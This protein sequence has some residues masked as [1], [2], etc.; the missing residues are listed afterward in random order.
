MKCLR[1]I[2]MSAVLL[3]SLLMAGSAF[4]DKIVCVADGNGND[5]C[6]IT[7][8]NV[9][10][11]STAYSNVSLAPGDTVTVTAQGCVQTGGSGATWKRYVDPS[12]PNSDH[13]Y[14]GLISIP[15]VT[16][17]LV[18]LSTV[19]GIVLPPSTGG[20]LTL[21]Y[22]D[23]DYSDNGYWSH[24]DGTDGQCSDVSDPQSGRASLLLVIHHASGPFLP[25]NTIYGMCQVQDGLHDICHIDR[26]DVTHATEEYLAISLRPGDTVGI[27]AQGC[28]QTGGGGST[29][30]RYVNPSGANSDHLYHGLIS[31]PGVTSGMVRLSTVVGNPSLPPSTGGTL[32]L[33]YEDDDYSDNGYWSHDDG[34]EDQCKGIGAASLDLTITHSG[35]GLDGIEITQVIQNMSGSV[36]LIAAKTTWARA[37]LSSTITPSKTVTATL[38]IRNAATVASVDITASAPSVLTPGISLRARRESWTGSLNFLLPASIVAA[39]TATYEVL[40]ITDSA[41]GQPLACMNCNF[42]KVV[43]FTTSPA[44]R[45]RAIGLQYTT[46]TPP[47]A[48]APV[49]AD[50]TLLSSWLLRAYPVP[51]IIFTNTTI[52]STNTWPFACTDANAQLAAIRGNDVS[53]GTD[54]R[55]HYLG[56][57][58]NGGGYMRGCASG[59]PTTADPTTV[60]SAPTGNPVGPNAPI[61]AIGDTDASFGDWY[62]GHELSHTFGRAHPGF[63]NGNSKDDLS[64]PNPNGQISDDLGTDTGLDVGDA[65]AAIALSVL[66]GASHFDIMTYCNQ[67][68]WFSAYNFASVRTRLHDEDTSGASDGPVA[69]APKGATHR[70][71]PAAPALKLE[72]GRFIHVV[73]TVDITAQTGKIRYV[74]PVKK[75]APQEPSRLQAE[76]RALTAQGQLIATYKVT[77][78]K[79]TDVPPREH[80]T[81]LIDAA[82]PYSEKIGRIQLVLTDKVNDEFR[83]GQQLPPSPGPAKLERIA[84]G[85]TSP[86]PGFDYLLRWKPVT[87]PGDHITYTV[88][89]SDDDSNWLTIGIG[90][91]KPLLGITRENANSRFLRVT[92]TNGFRNSEPVT[93]SRHYGTLKI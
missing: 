78:R 37:Y 34:T 36:P 23:D 50:F 75:A 82:V 83:A 65:A 46:G 61:N 38:R 15:G 67:P 76:L 73:A 60:A 90:I 32:T 71:Q 19:V 56:L 7:F 72:N 58:A 17:G 10:A 53:N 47:V 11:P 68:Q 12:G 5:T 35:I 26:P 91:I 18:R 66:P 63:C 86:A 31:I 89:A 62:G 43:T 29:W 55:T 81:A 41:T 49:A 33:G 21:G 14:H 28:V 52:A 51:S 3:G 87:M 44:L 9:M 70:P 69:G 74:N 42:P 40:S 39:G 24:D 8:P 16:A 80:Q 1:L 84:K 92:A 20:T 30:K 88:E 54:S 6:S 93:R 77:L 48:F 64:F 22:E 13:L 27:S 59:I 4:A 57:A 45:V 85:V 2:S 25:A 79:D